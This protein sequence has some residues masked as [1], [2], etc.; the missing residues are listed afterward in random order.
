MINMI[1]LVGQTWESLS[2]EERIEMLSTANAVDA[3]TCE[4]PSESMECVV[5]FRNLDVSIN[6]YYNQET[7]QIYI[8]D[9]A[10]F[11]NPAE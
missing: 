10:R 3:A 1:N 2:K 8:D 7:N 9:S 11:Y 4:I 6:G 5:D